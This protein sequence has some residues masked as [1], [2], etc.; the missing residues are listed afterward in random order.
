MA[1]RKRIRWTAPQEGGGCDIGTMPVKQLEGKEQGDKEWEA[2]RK[3]RSAQ[4]VRI[5]NRQFS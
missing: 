3:G 2:E 4:K 5:R 1:L